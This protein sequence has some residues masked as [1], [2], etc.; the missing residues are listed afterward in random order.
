MQIKHLLTQFL[1]SYLVERQLEKSLGFLSEHV[2]SLGTGVQEV[3]LN[4]NELRDLMIHEFE[5]IPGGFRYE[6]SHYHEYAYAENV[7]GAY[8]SVLT[9][10]EEDG[11][12]LSFQ[13]RLT[14]TAAKEGTEWKIISLHMSA[15]SDQQEGEEFFPIKYGREAVG[16]LEAL[17]IQAD[18]IL[19]HPYEADHWRFNY[20]TEEQDR[21]Y[22]R[23]V[24][25]RLSAYS[26]V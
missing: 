3:A 9:T 26:N 21:R 6:I 20:M 10:M 22:L 8:C 11:V 23:Y 14:M 4:K 7:S 2:M 12:T 5:S 24:I 25:A 16:K 17:G 19:F 13:T 18:V 15:P 1:D